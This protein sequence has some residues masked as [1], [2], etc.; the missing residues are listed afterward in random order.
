M[1]EKDDIK[2]RE[3]LEWL[4]ENFTG[5]FSVDF[6][7]DDE[8]IINGN[9]RLNNY[10][11]TELKYPFAVV[12]GDFNI[13][14]DIFPGEGQVPYRSLQT[15]KNCPK[16]VDG[17]FYCCSNAHL[18]SLEGGPEKVGNIYRCNHCDLENLNGIAKEI[19]SWIKAFGNRRLRD[20]SALKDVEIHKTCDF[21]F[22]DESLLQTETYKNL[23]EN[24]KI[25]F[26]PPIRWD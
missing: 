4:K 10:D 24:H 11:M 12:H 15:L 3:I 5:N 22:A 8:I 2:K 23:L 9:I 7:P 19:G 17:S 16:V 1:S 13:G 20:I 26:S 14:G 18:T 6:T 21:E 25:Y